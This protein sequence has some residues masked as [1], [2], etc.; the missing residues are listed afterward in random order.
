[1]L[2]SSS[3]LATA[4]LASCSA[5]ATPALLPSVCGASAAEDGAEGV[6]EMFVFCDDCIL[7]EN[8]RFDR[9]ARLGGGGVGRLCL[10]RS[11][12]YCC[13]SQNIKEKRERGACGLARRAPFG[14]GSCLGGCSLL[15]PRMWWNLAHLRIKGVWK[16]TAAVLS[17]P[18]TRP[19]VLLKLSQLSRCILS[20]RMVHCGVPAAQWFDYSHRFLRRAHQCRALSGGGSGGDHTLFMH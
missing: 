14:S 8:S 6:F 10:D 1:M 18:Q 5:T 4:S 3:V 9:Q 17:L 7:V 13:L 19:F 20:P 16:L 12:A 15:V 2:A 11:F